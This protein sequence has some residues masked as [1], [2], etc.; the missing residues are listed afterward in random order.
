MLEN[1]TVKRAYTTERA[2]GEPKEDYQATRNTGGTNLKEIERSVTK[3]N[4]G[5]LDDGK[6]ELTHQAGRGGAKGRI[7]QAT[8][9]TRTK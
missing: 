6:R 8:R 4:D 2:R 7:T 3:C 5:Q 9:K 1:L